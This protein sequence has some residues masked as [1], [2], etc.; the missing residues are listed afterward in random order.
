MILQIVVVDD[1][2]DEADVAGPVVFGLGVRERDVEAE[3]WELLLDL[4]EVLFV[5]DLLLASCTVPVRDLTACVER[6]EEVE[7]LST[8]RSHTSTTTDVEH[9]SIRVLDVEVPVRTAHADLV[10]RLQREDVGRGDTRRDG[11]PLVR[12]AVHRRRSDT[13]VERDDVPFGRVVSHRV[14]TDGLRIILTGQAPHIEVI[15][16]ATELLIDVVVGILDVVGRDGDLC[17]ATTLEVHHF[18]LRELHDEFLDEGRD[19][20]VRD[21]FALPFLDAEDGFRYDDL[22]VF[23]DLGLA[24]QT[25]VFLLLLAREEARL[26]RQDF[27]TTFDDTAAALAARTATTA[28]GGEVDILTLQSAQQRTADGY[29]SFLL[30]IDGELD[31]A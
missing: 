8:Q 3:V 15:P 27:P 17:V 9:L 1:L 4:A 29:F 19:V 18:A 6:A 14:S 5:E 16:V 25:P 28:S 11:E 23:L 20:A 31:V 7:D 10:P 2:M 22:H 13:D 26:R 24:S 30:P 21:D 12:S